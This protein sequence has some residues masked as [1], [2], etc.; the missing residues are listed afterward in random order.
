MC[1]T[2]DRQLRGNKAEALPSRSRAWQGCRGGVSLQKEYLG[3]PETGHLSEYSEEGRG[4]LKLLGDEPAPRRQ[5]VQR[6]RGASGP[7]Q[8]AHGA[9][10]AG[11]TRPDRDGLGAT[12]VT[13]ALR[14]RA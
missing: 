5:Q 3:S 7:G 6:A 11:R 12:A 10:A 4:S 13:L 14:L 2:L 8:K 9:G 1:Q